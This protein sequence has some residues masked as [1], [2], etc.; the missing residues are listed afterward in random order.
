MIHRDRFIN[1]D[2]KVI[3]KIR[4]RATRKFGGIT[5]DLSLR[6]DDLYIRPFIESID[7]NIGAITFRKGKPELCATFGWRDLGCYIVVSQINAVI[8]RL[9]NFRFMRKP[10]LTTILR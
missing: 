9:H 4:Q 2:H 7:D 1:V 5:Y 3:L 10:A 6:R 8:V